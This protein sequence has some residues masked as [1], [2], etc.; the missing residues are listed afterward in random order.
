MMNKLDKSDVRRHIKSLTINE[1]ATL[2]NDITSD[3]QR[4]Q[5]VFTETEAFLSLAEH[6][7]KKET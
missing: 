3:L 1:I 2:I 6:S 4:R 7:L 5:G